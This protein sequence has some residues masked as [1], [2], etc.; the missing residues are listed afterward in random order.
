MNKHEIHIKKINKRF[1]DINNS[2]FK[3]LE[4]QNILNSIIKRKLNAHNAMKSLNSEL[5]FKIKDSI[6]SDIFN[7]NASTLSSLLV[8]NTYNPAFTEGNINTP[9][10]GQ[11]KAVNASRHY[12]FITLPL[13]KIN[14]GR[15]NNN[16]KNNKKVNLGKF[17]KKTIDINNRNNVLKQKNYTYFSP[18]LRKNETSNNK[19]KY[20]KKINEKKIDEVVIN[21]P[22]NLNYESLACRTECNEKNKKINYVSEY[23]DKNNKIKNQSL[24]NIIIY[25]NKESKN[26]NQYN[27]YSSNKVYKKK[28]IK[29]NTYNSI[30]SDKYKDN[31]TSKSNTNTNTSNDKKDYEKEKDKY[32]QLLNNY[33]KNVVKQFMVYFRPYYYTFIKKYFHS[34]I[35]NLKNIK[36]NEKNSKTKKYI[37]KINKRNI[38]VNVNHVN[39]G[40]VIKDVK[41][42]QLN[43]L[44]NNSINQNKYDKEINHKNLNSYNIK[45]SKSKIEPLNTYKKLNNIV[46]NNNNNF[47]FRS[48]Q[49]LKTDE[50][51]RNNI[52]LEKKLSQ[53]LKRKH[54]KKLL[55]ND[56]IK[57]DYSNSQ[58]KNENNT[59]DIS[60]HNKK[61]ITINNSYDR[62]KNRKKYNTPH[63]SHLMISY[64]SLTNEDIPKEE[65]I[66]IDKNKYSKIKS[67]QTIPRRKKEKEKDNEIKGVILKKKYYEEVISPE[68]RSDLSRFKNNENIYLLKNTFIRIRK[69]NKHLMLSKKDKIN[70]INNSRY[71]KNYISKKIKNIFTRDKKINIYINYVFFIPQK[72]KKI[73]LKKINQLLKISHN[74]SYTYIGKDNHFIHNN[75]KNKIYSKKKLTSIKEEEEKSRCSISLLLQNSKTLDEYNSIIIKL[76][77][78]INNYYI[79][80]MKKGFLYNL[81]M[82]NLIICLKN[83]FKNKSF[84]KIKLKSKEVKKDNTFSNQQNKGNDS[85][86]IF[87]SDDKIIM[88]M[89][90]MNSINYENDN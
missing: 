70:N 64:N 10:V 37:K 16:D 82:I 48:K 51:Y 57:V 19:K 18:Y 88:N 75:D 34:F 35:S 45:K 53:I 78:N 89:N 54:R 17:T 86:I 58:N 27:N 55:T 68:Y 60:L 26:D 13:E 59:L 21:Y 73:N 72:Q 42:V 20:E 43:Y 71:N 90:N 8:K 31:N 83:I 69:K 7:N 63:S 4:N 1:L 2:N 56:F 29:N 81:K 52:E 79:I 36:N 22:T 11:I 24:K 46:I 32:L 87:L 23:S 6:A 30:K 41:L 61:I 84:K 47:N 44:N 15:M 25:E 28:A 66:N 40:K 3:K 74:F 76:V 50:L 85:N 14:N 9:K 49:N 67:I 77:K 5:S 12:N 80:K 39:N 65:S 62:W 38:Y 33:R